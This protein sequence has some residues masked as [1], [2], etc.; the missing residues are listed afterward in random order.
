MIWESEACARWERARGARVR[1]PAPPPHIDLTCAYVERSD[2]PNV[3][4]GTLHTSPLRICCSVCS[5]GRV[6]SKEGSLRRSTK[7]PLRHFAEKTAGLAPDMVG[8]CGG[9]GRGS[10]GARRGAPTAA[11]R[12]ELFRVTD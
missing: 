5:D 4:C 10:R 7:A 2:A 11:A 9:W 12:R 6:P 8:E 1:H 3:G